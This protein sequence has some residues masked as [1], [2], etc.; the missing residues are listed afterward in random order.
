MVA[1]VAHEA[2]VRPPALHLNDPEPQWWEGTG[3]WL[4]GLHVQ[5]S[6]SALACLS[7][8]ERARAAR[9]A[10]DADRRRY[11]AAHVALR[12]RLAGHLGALPQELAFHLGEH[13]KPRV[14]AAGAA[15]HFSLSHAGDIALIGVC[16]HHEIGVDIEAVRRVSDVEELGAA[17]LGPGECKALQAL[18]GGARDRA[19]LRCWTRKEA[20]LKALGTGLSLSPL[21]FEAGLTPEAADVMIPRGRGHARVVVRSLVEASESLEPPWVGAVAWRLGRA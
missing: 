7:D 8:L 10:F 9:F 11:L 20:C 6:E 14:G 13:G 15:C 12:E 21:A 3:L 17:V 4:V 1:M 5:P 18:E 16:P 19:F 2:S